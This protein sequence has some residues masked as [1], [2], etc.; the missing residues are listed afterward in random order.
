MNVPGPGRFVAALLALLAAVPAAGNVDIA[1]DFL[2]LE[3]AT[4]GGLPVRW[5]TCAEPCT[6][7]GREQRILGSGAGTMTW[8]AADPALAAALAAI[9]YD[10]S[11]EATPTAH[12]V[13][14]TARTRLAGQRLVQR[15]TVARTNH[16]VRAEWQVPAGVRLAFGSG[17][18]FVP[19]PLPGFGAAFTDVEVVRVGADGQQAVAAGEAREPAGSWLG[20]R[21]RF[22]AVLARG[23]AP[24]VV[25]IDLPDQPVVT[26]MPAGGHLDLEIYAGPVEHGALRAVAPE[27]DGLLFAGLWAPLRALC[28]GLFF[29]LEALLAVVPDAGLAIILVSLAVKVILWPLTRIADRWQAEVNRIQSRIQPRIAAIRR[30]HRGETAH[31]LTLQV[32]REAGVHP[33]FTLKSLAGFAIQVPMF[34]AAFDMLADNFALAGRGFLWI[35]DLAAPDRFAPLPFALPFFGSDFNLMPALMTLLTVASALVQ[36]EESLSP[37]LQGRQRRQLY[38]MAVA[39]FLL[40]YTFPAGMV[41]YWTANNGWHLL[42]IVLR[43]V[44]PRG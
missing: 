10:A 24:A 43:Q 22:W 37:Q 5:T 16:V 13:V 2:R 6:G 26:W 39:F 38:A 36:R 32:Y 12:V 9:E 28:F 3:L 21:Q 23:E 40:F 18:A 20:P 11:I 41:L 44:R 14:L 27:L 35:T 42:K 25:D 1:T 17:A 19:A 7:G 33:L 31:D 29:L 4:T 8:T 34:I 15:Y 30:E